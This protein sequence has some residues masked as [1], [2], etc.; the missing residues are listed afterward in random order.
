VFPSDHKLRDPSPGVRRRHRVREK[1]LGSAIKR[2]VRQ[3]Q[4]SK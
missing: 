1:T 3:V 2:A 4:I